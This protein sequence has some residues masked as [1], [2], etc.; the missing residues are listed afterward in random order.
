MEELIKGLVFSLLPSAIIG[1]G[2]WRIQKSILHIDKKRQE[3]EECREEHQIVLLKSINA[4]IAL[5]EATAI[6]IRDQ[7]CNGEVTGA[8]AYAKQVKNEQREFYQK[9]GIKKI[10]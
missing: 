10:I 4:A 5:G 3:A 2:V 1:L 8:L 6:A 7:K 9:Q